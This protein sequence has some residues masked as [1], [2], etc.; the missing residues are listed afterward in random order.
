[1]KYTEYDST[2]RKTERAFILGQVWKQ[3]GK[4]YGDIIR[5]QVTIVEPRIMELTNCAT[6]A[7]VYC[8]R[9]SISSFT[10]DNQLTE[11]GARI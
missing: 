3:Y 7:K 6:L 10:F 9:D 1:M 2:G 5:W 11:E 4:D 8:D